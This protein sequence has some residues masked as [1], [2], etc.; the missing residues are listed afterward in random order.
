[1]AIRIKPIGKVYEPKVIEK[2]IKAEIEKG[3][4][5]IAQAL[6]EDITKRVS[7]YWL[8]NRVK[9]LMKRARRIGAEFE[10]RIAFYIAEYLKK[11]IYRQK[12]KGKWKPLS[13]NYL[14]YKKKKGLDTR[15]LLAYHYYVRSITAYRSGNDWVVGTKPFQRHPK[16]LIPM[17]K[18]A[19]YLEFG[20]R[21][22][23]ARPHWRPAF[24]EA[25]KNAGKVMKKVL[26]DVKAFR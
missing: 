22:M 26:K 9:L 21:K 4:Y 17:E 7:P 8:R 18:L 1:M 14:S 24:Y 10:R 3:T 16:T 12:W 6:A 5:Q 15:T 25:Q 11:G 13:P 19:R 23:P 20:T 2:T